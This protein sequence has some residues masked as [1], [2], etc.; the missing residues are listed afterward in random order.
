[1]RI[2]L[3]APLPNPTR[4]YSRIPAKVGRDIRPRRETDFA[5]ISKIN[6]AANS[7]A[8]DSNVAQPTPVTPAFSEKAWPPKNRLSSANRNSILTAAIISTI[9]RS[10]NASN[11]TTM[12][13]ARMVKGTLNMLMPK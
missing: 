1:M 8:L 6:P 11:N 2:R 9:I 7:P 4:R 12:A 13:A 10:P 3:S 5:R